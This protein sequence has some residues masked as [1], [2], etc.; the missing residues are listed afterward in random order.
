MGVGMHERRHTQG[1]YDRVVV[2]LSTYAIG[3]HELSFII[4]STVITII[5]VSI[6]SK[7]GEARKCS[8]PSIR[9]YGISLFGF[10]KGLPT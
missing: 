4:L 7:A 6:G 9:I 2:Y 3:A 5:P 8:L 1:I 10:E